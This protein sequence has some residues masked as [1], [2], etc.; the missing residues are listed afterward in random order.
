MNKD[1]LFATSSQNIKSHVVECQITSLVWP[2]LSLTEKH[3]TV[4]HMIIFND[5]F[6]KFYQYLPRQKEMPR[7]LNF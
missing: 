7:Q 6:S 3:P 4:N 2:Y 5:L 1:F